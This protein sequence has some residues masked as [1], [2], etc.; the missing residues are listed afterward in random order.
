MAEETGVGAHLRRCREERGL[1]LEEVAAATRILPRALRGLE[2]DRLEDLPAPVYVR[3]FIR[4]YCL[5]VGV[6]PG[7]AL[8]LYEAY[9]RGRQPLPPA[10][11]APPPLAGRIPPV[12]W[13]LLRGGAVLAGLLVIAMMGVGLYRLTPVGEV[14]PTR[15]RLDRREGL[16]P[17]RPVVSQE[18]V[19]ASIVGSPGSVRLPR[20][21]SDMRQTA[22]ALPTP[23]LQAAAVPDA[24]DPAEREP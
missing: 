20:R 3:G 11:E 5:R 15:A 24:I 16:S 22:E 13:L 18:P 4:A 9:L 6:L 1:S 14:G 17:P 12:A 2:E 21:S 8:A 23:G 7:R 10:V 19:Q